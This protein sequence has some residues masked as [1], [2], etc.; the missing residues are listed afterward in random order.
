MRANT[1]AALTIC[2]FFICTA[3]VLT[4]GKTGELPPPSSQA[5]AEKTPP[6]A[7]TEEISEPQ[8]PKTRFSLFSATVTAQTDDGNHAPVSVVLRL[9]QHTGETSVLTLLV[10]SSNAFYR[11]TPIQ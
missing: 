3:I 2:T 10:T 4:R 9:D 1:A 8:T 11:F 6:R 7:F 5:Q